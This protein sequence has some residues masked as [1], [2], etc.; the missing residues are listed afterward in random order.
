MKDIKF[1]GVGLVALTAASAGL[2]L[3]APAMADDSNL[4]KGSGFEQKYTT[5]GAYM[6]GDFH[7]HTTC[8]D[9]ATSVQT[10][11]GKSLT[12]LD[13]FIQSD[14]SGNGAR[15]CRFDDFAYNADDDGQGKLWEDSIGAAAIKGDVSNVTSN[16]GK[17]ADGTIRTARAMWRWQSLQ[18]Y[19]FPTIVEERIKAGEPAFAGMEWTVPGHEHTS[20]S[21]IAGQYD[22]VPNSSALAWFEY[23][24]AAPSEDTSQG[25][26]QG[27]TCGVNAANNA[28]LVDR[29]SV[30]PV[31]QG[32]ANYNGSLSTQG[33]NIK[34]TGDHVKST[35]GVYWVQQNYAGL[36]YIVPA[37]LERAGPFRP[38][39][40]NG[41]NIEHLRD[42]NN[43]APD[44]A[45]GFESQPG[46][47][48]SN[49]RGEYYASRNGNS[50]SAGMFTF[51]GTGC[52]AGAEAARPGKDFNGNSLTSADF[53]PTGRFPEVAD[54]AT[55]AFVVV[56][57]PGVRTMWDALLSEGRHWWFFA[58]SDWHNRGSFQ[59]FDVKSDNDFWP[60]EYQK[61]YSFIKKSNETNPNPAQD[62]VNGL[63]SGNGFV[64]TG[65][66]IDDITFSA[67]SSNA[68]CAKMGE[69]LTVKKGINVIVTLRIHD[70]AGANNSPYGFNNPALLQ[71]GISKPINQPDV[72]QVDLIQGEVRAKYDPVANADAYR[73]PLAPDTTKIAT[74]WT[75]GTWT[76]S[77]EW[78]VMTF[79]LRN[80]TT[81]KYVRVRGY[82]LP[83]GTPYKRDPNG[84]PLS[85]G[86]ASN[87]ACADPA[88]PSHVGGKFDADVEGWSDLSFFSNP[89][90]IRV[91]G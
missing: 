50:G 46:H 15:D 83:A 28:K 90:F 79:I 21:I 18:E 85:D 33:I 47:Q 22:H 30:D 16:T 58:S 43:A 78:K 82:N 51:G 4:T 27:W 34:D 2:M 80:I 10:L 14:H 88:C 72:A 89:I 3:A 65:S 12:N 62:I 31:N 41:Y 23:C 8:S 57:R 73:D 19:Q 63:R 6:S 55:P 87:I 77:G 53:L 20:M 48:A 9:G 59:P 7:N 1:G 26:G 52:Y 67:C 32:P 44:V 38:G 42:W 25:G 76:T 64:A 54:T 84:N 91:G 75:E 45:F 13:W 69:T 61:T 49:D 71:V 56:C 60:G 24:F 39:A 36:G 29:F 5:A 35:A 37:H 81:D 70:P 66:L 40:N 74:S 11:V 68:N 86:L 17:N